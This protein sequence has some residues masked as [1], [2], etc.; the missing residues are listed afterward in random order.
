MRGVRFVSLGMLAS[1]LWLGEASSSFANDTMATI[2]AGGLQFQKTDEVRMER[3]D[4]YLSPKGVRVAYEFRNLTDHDVRMTVAFPMP[5]VDVL[6]MSETPHKFHLSSREG[7]IFDFHVQVNGLEIVT[8]L[9]ARAYKADQ[10]DKEVTAILKKSKMPLLAESTER[11][12]DKPD[13]KVLDAE[14]LIDQEGLHPNWI[15]RTNFHWEQ[16]FP[17]GQTIQITHRYKPVVGADYLSADEPQYPSYAQW[18]PDK[19]FANATKSLPPDTH[20]ML[21]AT[22]LEYILKTGANWAGPIRRFRLEIDKAGADLLS[23]C[24]MPGLQLQR[25]GQAFVAEASEYTPTS[26][27]KILFVDRACEK[28]PCEFGA[29]LPGLRH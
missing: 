28:A 8:A 24:P 15:V 25:R 5:D 4:L 26:D 16:V 2:G 11:G 1:G 29:S 23:L 3:E 13:L 14:G 21:P 10:P 9:D 7:D 22:T 19:A 17:A 27:I 18:C 12:H 20:G 6:G